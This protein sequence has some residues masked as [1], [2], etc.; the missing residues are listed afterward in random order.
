M[1]TLLL[2]LPA[3]NKVHREIEVNGWILKLLLD[4]SHKHSNLFNVPAEDLA[5]E[6]GCV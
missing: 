2:W 3:P 5:E 4:L 1:Y 6:L